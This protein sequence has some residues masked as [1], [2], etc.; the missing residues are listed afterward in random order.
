MART[1]FF[2]LCGLMPA[3]AGQ[4]PEKAAGYHEA[5]RKRPESEALFTRFRDAWLE[6]KPAG[7][8][9]V[10][11]LS[12]AEA[13]EPGA[14]G[15]LGRARFAAGKED[16]ALAAFGKAIEAE[17]AAA[18]LRLAR[19]KI[20][21]AR[22]E[23]AAAEKD[24]LAV[25]EGG[26]RPEALKLAGLAC[27]RGERMEDALAH[28]KKAVETAPGDKSLL[29]DLTELA[30]REGRYDLALDF[31]EK[32]RDATDDAYGK[33]MATLKRSELLLASQRLE[34]AMGELGRRV[35][36]GA[37]GAGP[38]GADLSAA[39]RC[40]RLGEADRRVGG[41]QSGATEFPPRPIPGACC[42]G[43]TGQGAGGS[44]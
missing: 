41:C 40:D 22:S 9:E 4:M 10:E 35:V 3:M 34:E 16:E 17:P 30:R 15:I 8:L 11:L 24:A 28:W 13:G 31:C 44:G 27:L 29:E 39:R 5:L 21:L 1:W 38:G 32:W 20:L 18:W 19:A 33:A 25:P 6:E 36:A 14:W 7:D 42:G 23:F 26:M 12:R 2:L 43:S 37:R